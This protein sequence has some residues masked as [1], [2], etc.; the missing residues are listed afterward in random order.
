MNKLFS[1]SSIKTLFGTPSVKLGSTQVTAMNSINEHFVAIGTILA[2][3]KVSPEHAEIAAQQLYVSSLA[4]GA[5]VT[6]GWN[7]GQPAQY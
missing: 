2:E 7:N 3:G 1:L 4:V 5:A 6:Y